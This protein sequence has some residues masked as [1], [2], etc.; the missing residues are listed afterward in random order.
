M[1]QYRSCNMLRYSLSCKLVW[2]CSAHVNQRSSKNCIIPLGVGAARGD[3]SGLG[4]LTQTLNPE[5]FRYTRT[6]DTLDIGDSL[7]IVANLAM[8][9]NPRHPYNGVLSAGSIQLLQDTNLRHHQIRK[10][11]SQ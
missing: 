7:I 6:I 8:I 11:Y 3:Y 5:D 10:T 4:F 1:L 9:P 2:M